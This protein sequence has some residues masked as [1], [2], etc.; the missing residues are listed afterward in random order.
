MGLVWESGRASSV[1]K[2]VGLGPSEDTAWEFDSDPPSPSSRVSDL[3]MRP[4]LTSFVSAPMKK[5][6]CFLAA[7]A[8]LALSKGM[9]SQTTYPGR[10]KRSKISAMASSNR[11][12]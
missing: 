11:F 1:G 12:R 10:A 2:T 8:V 5:H 4:R 7:S 3:L 9:G 6:P